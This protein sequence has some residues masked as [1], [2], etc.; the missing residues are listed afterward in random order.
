[1][2]NFVLMAAAV[3]LGFTLQIGDAEAKRL[4]GG[5]F[6]GM[7]RQSVAPSK[8]T[9]AAPTRQQ[10][11][12]GA[13]QAQP[14][15]SWMGPLAGLAAGLGLAALASHFGFGEGMANIL[16]IG[17]L[18]MGAVMLFRFLSRNKTGATRAGGLQYAAADTNHGGNAPRQ[19]DFMPAG[20][21]AVAA[22]TGGNIPTDFDVESFVRNAKV[23]FIRLQAA[24]DA[25]NLD[26][27]REFTS[28][29]MFA[30]IKMGMSERG[31]GKQETDVAQLNGEVLDVAEEANRYIVSIRFTGLIS[32]E[33]GAAPAPFDEIWHMTKPTDNSRGWVLAGIQQVQ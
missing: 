3:V 31:D 24:N 16:M 20:G 6:S 33:K 17:L 11:A 14:K 19:P 15:R 12:A 13:A 27:I 25:G 2:K 8:S 9:N 32:E 30:E 28:P 29:E 4:G 21:S 10:S 5:G 22:T 7:Q 18:I 23:N 1:M 26:D